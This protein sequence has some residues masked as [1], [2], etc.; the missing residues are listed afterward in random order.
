[1]VREVSV[2]PIQEILSLLEASLLI[3]LFSLGMGCY[4]GRGEGVLFCFLYYAL[5]RSMVWRDGMYL[6]DRN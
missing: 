5:G 2:V 4:W 6:T 3:L 1:M